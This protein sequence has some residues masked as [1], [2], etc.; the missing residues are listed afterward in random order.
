MTTNPNTAAA[1]LVG[2]Q[3][4]SMKAAA[5][6]SGGAMTG[7]MGMGM[8]MNAGGGMNAQNLF[9]MG[10]QQAQAAPQQ[11][12]AGAANTWTCSCG[13]TVSGK[14]LSG[15]RRKEAGTED[16]GGRQLDLRK[17]R[18]PG[19]RKVLSGVRS[20]ETG[21]RLDLFLRNCEQG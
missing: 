4:D 2:G 9:A 20:T 10:Q 13:A 11:A 8:A 21:R 16:A 15:V 19:Y 12:Q 7:F 1:R 18:H 3:I 5:S 14:I 17:M 6:N